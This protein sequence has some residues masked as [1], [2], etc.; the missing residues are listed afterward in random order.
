VGFCPC[1][2]AYGQVEQTVDRALQDSAVQAHGHNSALRS[3]PRY[4]PARVDDLLEPLVTHGHS[5]REQAL[6]AVM[7]KLLHAI[8]GMLRTNTDFDGSKFRKLPQAA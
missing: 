6:V 8:Y 2:P 1:C 7:R 4:R 5:H 3:R